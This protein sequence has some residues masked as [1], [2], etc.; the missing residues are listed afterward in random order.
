[1]H[2]NK[3]LIISYYDCFNKKDWNGLI[4]L[5]DDNIIHDRN[6]EN[7]VIGKNAFHQFLLAMSECY[8]EKISDLAIFEHNTNNRF[9]TE[10][11][12]DGSYIQTDINLPP[13]TGQKYRLSAGAFF[14]V[15][16]NK[17]TRVTGYYNL[18]EWIGLIKA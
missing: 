4:D 11:T 7:R 8:D 16:H 2:A 3:N 17:I 13:A 9:A 15:N 18:N 6:Q 1:M 10:F 12:V 5:L 14:Q